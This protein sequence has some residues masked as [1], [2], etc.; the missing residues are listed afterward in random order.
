MNYLILMS[1]LLAT[2]IHTGDTTKANCLCFQGDCPMGW[3]QYRDACY[4]PMMFRTSWINAEDTCQRNYSGAHLASIHTAEENDYIFALMGS[5]SFDEKEK[6]YWIGLHDTLIEG[7][8][9]W[10]DGSV[11][12]YLPFGVPQP[13]NLGNEDYVGS[14]YIQNGVVTWNDYGPGW[15]FPFICKFSF[16]RCCLNEGRIR[17]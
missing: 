3:F 11:S 17:V 6:A 1:G 15:S 4:Q 12:D 8:F 16:N 2:F 7:R 9:M 14:W 5:P 10:T 13:D